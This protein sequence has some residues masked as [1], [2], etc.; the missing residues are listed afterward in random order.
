M[1][2][3]R[4][5][6]VSLARA[7]EE[8]RINDGDL[9]LFRGTGIVS[10]LI[11]VAGRGEYSHAALVGFNGGGP[12]VLENREFKGGRAVTLKSQ[13]EQHDGRIDLFHSQATE[14]QRMAAVSYAWSETGAVYGWWGLLMAGLTH[15]PI[16]RMIRRPSNDDEEN[17]E[18]PQF[19]SYMIA[20]AYRAA[21][22]D[23][24][25]ELAD[26]FTEPSDLARSKVFERAFTLTMGAA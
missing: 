20:A 18:R 12:M 21:G 19:C 16:W 22:V 8:D 14:K 10:F 1:E 25:D 17:F 9:L 6:K 3:K 11:K 24:V 23:V 13:V 7:I 15:L 2:A 4:R 5:N 26:S